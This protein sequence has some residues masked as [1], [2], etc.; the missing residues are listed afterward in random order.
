MRPFL[1]SHGHP[2]A[3]KKWAVMNTDVPR[4]CKHKMSSKL[5]DLLEQ[6]LGSDIRWL[7]ASFVIEL[8]PTPMTGTGSVCLICGDFGI[9]CG[10]D[11][12]FFNSHPMDELYD[13]RRWCA[14]CHGT[15]TSGRGRGNRECDCWRVRRMTSCAECHVRLPGLHCFG[16]SPSRLCEP[17]AAAAQPSGD[18]TGQVG[19][20]E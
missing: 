16:S 10:C 15:T 11:F 8:S 2:R 17:C 18:R 4:G 14:S 19:G 5:E 1:I 12:Y 13:L 6:R 20:A 7:I 9:L 3:V